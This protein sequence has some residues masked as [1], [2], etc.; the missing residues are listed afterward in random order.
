MTFTTIGRTVNRAEG[1]DKVTGSSEYAADVK[2]PGML[3]GKVLRSPFPHAKILNIDVSRARNLPG[4]HLVITGA[5]LPD[6]R[7]GRFLRD[8]P[9]LANGKVLFAGEK[10]V[11]VAADTPE[12]ADEALLLVDVEYEPVEAVFDSIDA[13]LDSAPVLHENMASYVGLPQPVSRINNVFAHNSWS[14]GEIIDGFDQSDRIFEHTFNAQM[15]HQ[16]YIEPHACVVEVSDSGNVQ[17]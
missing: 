1:P 14:K 10:V 16:A 5:D 7:V 15:M 4:V 11:A 13:M 17:I 8:I 3:W 12:L 6:A 2:R 9:I